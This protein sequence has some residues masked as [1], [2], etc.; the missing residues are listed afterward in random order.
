MK[1]LVV[2]L[3]ILS[4]PFL[5]M[6]LVGLSPFDLKANVQVGTGIG[7]KLACSGRYLSGFDP[8]QIAADIASYSAAAELLTIGYDDVE[9]IAGA[10]LL[11]F[12]LTEAKYRPGLGCTLVRSGSEQ[13]NVIEVPKIQGS[14]LPWPQGSIVNTLDNGEQSQL[15]KLLVKDNDD[16]LQTRALL[17]VRDGSIVS[18]VYAEGFSPQTPLMG[19]SMAKALSGIMLGHLVHVDELAVGEANLFEDWLLDERRNITLHQLLQMSS[20]L[21]FSEVYAP[22]SDATRMLF[23]EASASGVAKASALIHPPGTY[24]SYSSG[25]ANL[26][27]EMFVNRTGGTQSAVNVLYK[28][29]LQPMAMAHTT[30]ELDANGVFMGSSNIYSSTRD[31]ARL[32][33]MMLQNGELNGH[34]IVSE[35]WVAQATSPN[36]SDNERAYGYQVWLNEGDKTL[37]WPDLPVDA[38]AFTGNRGQ[39]VMIIPSAQTLIVRMGWSSEGYPDNLRFSQL[40]KL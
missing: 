12:G 2:L 8:Q 6:N 39:R 18:E 15:S 40:L 14:L 36:S 9:M 20:G 5:G 23:V 33:L 22:G 26:L 37:R 32:G 34:R 10:S 13:L 17:V 29:I 38:Y 7:A 35:Q 21:D 3:F 30:L 31:W 11:G 28:K 19:W 4:L 27:S 1:K 24:F 16:G 25:T